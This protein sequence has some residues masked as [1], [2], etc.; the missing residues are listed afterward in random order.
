MS[1]NKEARIL[2]GIKEENL[3][4]ILDAYSNLNS[5]SNE[6]ILE[7]GHFFYSLLLEEFNHIFIARNLYMYNENNIYILIRKEYIPIL[8]KTMFNPIILPM[9]VSPKM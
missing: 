9:I 6:S 1:V 3:Y 7:F 2:N 8:V 5:F 4:I